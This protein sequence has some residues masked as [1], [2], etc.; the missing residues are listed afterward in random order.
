MLVKFLFNM[1]KY[2]QSFVPFVSSS[3]S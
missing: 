1:T 3:I 2:A